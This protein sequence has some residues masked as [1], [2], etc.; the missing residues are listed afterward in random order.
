M[1]HSK[2][3]GLI[4]DAD[5]ACGSTGDEIISQL[6]PLVLLIGEGIRQL[7][8][9]ADQ[10]DDRM[11]S[12]GIYSSDKPTEKPAPDALTEAV[13]DFLASELC[14]GFENPTWDKYAVKSLKAAHEQAGGK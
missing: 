5:L 11:I 2:L 3:N 9:I 6:G 1:D 7:T 14:G 8:R 4:L 10:G 13:K 12:E